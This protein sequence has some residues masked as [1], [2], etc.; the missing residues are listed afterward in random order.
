MADVTDR[1]G[2]LDASTVRA[3]ATQISGRGGPGFGRGGWGWGGV[4]A[5]AAPI[6]MDV[7]LLPHAF[8]STPMLLAVTPFPSPLTTPPVT[9][10][11]FIAAAAASGVWCFGRKLVFPG[12]GIKYR[13][14][15]WT[16]SSPLLLAHVAER[17]PQFEWQR[18]AQRDAAHRV[19]ICSTQRTRYSRWQSIATVAKTASLPARTIEMLNSCTAMAGNEPM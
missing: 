6:L 2:R 8:S 18:A 17:Q 13:H 7:T 12:A 1:S 16:P 11:Y 19:L 14:S 5:R 15:A 9:R 3:A 4:T 10:T